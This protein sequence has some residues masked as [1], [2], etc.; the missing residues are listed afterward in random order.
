MADDTKAE[1]EA[2]LNESTPE[3]EDAWLEKH[4]SEIALEAQEGVGASRD[5]RAEEEAP[6]AAEED[7]ELE[8]DLDDFD[9]EDEGGEITGEPDEDSDEGGIEDMLEEARTALK[10]SGFTTKE[11]DGM[12]QEEVLARGLR[13]ARVLAKNDAAFR[14]LRETEKTG[15][16]PSGDESG[17]R[18]AEPAVPPEISGLAA[19]LAERL[20]LADEDAAALGAYGEAI[21][22]ASA[23]HSD[24]LQQRLSAQGHWIQKVGLEVSRLGL[25][26]RFPGLDK[27]S[28]W[29]KVQE[30]L[31]GLK[32]EHYAQKANPLRAMILDASRQLGLPDA[33]AAKGKARRQRRSKGAPTKATRA[34]RTTD[35]GSAD[36]RETAV[37]DEIEAK[38]GGP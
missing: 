10:K 30:Q 27:A 31:G 19:P 20:G 1:L 9:D 37:F 36:E 15:K 12:K 26:E 22:K 14:K 17:S 33:R 34:S 32:F 21:W 35:Q 38:W 3:G 2:A 23:K 4:D 24:G 18:D 16:G 28:T 7:E 11:I 6:E 5:D 8:A 25:R 29:S 13:R